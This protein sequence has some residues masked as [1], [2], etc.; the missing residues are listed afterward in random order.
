MSCLAQGPGPQAWPMGLA[1]RPRQLGSYWACSPVG[2]ADCAAH[3][4]QPILIG[5]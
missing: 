2:P 5:I 3:W 1:H 4:T